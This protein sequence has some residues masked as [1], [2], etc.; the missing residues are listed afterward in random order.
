[1]FV[2]FHGP[3]YQC[4]AVMLVVT[5]CDSR[6]C[7]TTARGLPYLILRRNLQHT[8]PPGLHRLLTAQPVMIAVP[9]A[10]HA[11]LLPD[12]SSRDVCSLEP[13]H[14][15]RLIRMRLCMAVHL[16]MMQLAVTSAKGCEDLKPELGIMSMYHAN[17]ASQPSR[18]GLMGLAPSGCTGQA[19]THTPPGLPLQHTH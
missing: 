5:C 1:M 19:G 13:S 6:T 15:N 2:V 8:K 14:S 18:K 17:P 11:A 12:E 16:D 9:P 3:G 7:A 4:P 10:Q